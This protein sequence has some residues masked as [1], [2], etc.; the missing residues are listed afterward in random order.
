M[1]Q[2]SIDFQHFDFYLNIMYVMFPAFQIF[3]PIRFLSVSIFTIY[4]KH[5][6]QLWAFFYQYDVFAV[7][8]FSK[9]VW[10]TFFGS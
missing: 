6:N 1:T 2:L 5:L 7:V 8:K 10:K 3:F 4:S 9:L